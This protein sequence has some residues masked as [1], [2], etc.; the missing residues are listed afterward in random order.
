MLLPFN[1]NFR[2]LEQNDLPLLY[3]WL[4]TAFVMEWFEKYGCTYSQVV[5]KFTPRILGE[6]PINCYII[7]Y[8]ATP[9]GYIQSYKIADFPEYNN[10]VR[11]DA[12]TIGLDLFIGHPDYIHRGMGKYILANFL[13]QFVFADPNISTCIIGP[14]PANQI[15]IRSYQKT[16]FRHFKTVHLPDENQ[17]E[18]LMCL[19]KAD[20]EAAE[21]P[22]NLERVG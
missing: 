6:K 9:I 13:R 4:N 11:A 3:R 12:H 2:K 14:E 7:Q 16:G 18:Y 1:L 21:R 15:A 17:P 8:V 20:F 5:D 22:A 19:T 10:V